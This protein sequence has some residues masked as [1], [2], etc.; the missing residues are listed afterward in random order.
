[1]L[2]LVLRVVPGGGDRV[3]LGAQREH[4]VLELDDAEL[5]DRRALLGLGE[6]DLQAG[7]PAVV[8]LAFSSRGDQLASASADGTVTVYSFGVDRLLERAHA[9]VGD[10]ELTA[11]ECVSLGENCS[12]EVPAWRLVLRQ[13]LQ[14]LGIVRGA[15]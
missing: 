6:P 1:V 12:S 2:A 13:I 14:S 15:M 11:A 9:I 5:R 4:V 7:G 3:Q 10:R 8:A